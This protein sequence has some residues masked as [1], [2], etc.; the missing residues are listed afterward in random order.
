MQRPASV[1]ANN[2]ILSGLAPEEWV[3]LRE[4]ADYVSFPAG[5]V[6]FQAGDP[7][8]SAYFPCT[9]LTAVFAVL[10]T[11]D[12]VAV[13]AIGTEGLIGTPAVLGIDW[14]PHQIRVQVASSG[15][16]IPVDTLLQTFERSPVF[17][18]LILEEI[19]RN[20][21]QVARS[22]V[23]NRFHSQRERVARWLL[24][25]TGKTEQPSVVITH[26]L[27][28]QMIGGPRHAISVVIADFRAKG[29]VQQVRGAIEVLDATALA[30]I[31]CDCLQTDLA[32][33]TGIAS[34]GG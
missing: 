20:Y 21:M 34:G 26:E 11:G 2:R 25:I 13:V 7:I 6:I 23:C 24:V 5:H 16:R 29:L 4:H 32:P 31:A 22:A 17:R 33:G 14:S 9:G 27:L 28:A 30:E 8:T 1:E 12:Q 18:R 3:T 10:P 15:Y 19:G